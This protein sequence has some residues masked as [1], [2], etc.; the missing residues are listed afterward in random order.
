M[1]CRALDHLLEEESDVQRIRHRKEQEGKRAE[2]KNKKLMTKRSKEAEMLKYQRKFVL[3]KIS[4][5]G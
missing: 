1:V 4:K 5:V 2:R 3:D